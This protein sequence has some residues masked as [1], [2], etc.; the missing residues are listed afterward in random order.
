M[1]VNQVNV[2]KC[3]LPVWSACVGNRHDNIDPLSIHCSVNV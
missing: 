3:G 2:N 1:V